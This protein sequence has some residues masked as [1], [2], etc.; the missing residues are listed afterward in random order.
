MVRAIVGTSLKVGIGHLSLKE[1][2]NII[3]AQ[4]RAKAYD[5]VLSKGLYL[6]EVCYPIPFG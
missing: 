6:A 1:F 3:I 5:S 4:N 2:E